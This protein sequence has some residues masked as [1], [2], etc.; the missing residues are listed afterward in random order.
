MSRS[1]RLRLAIGLLFPSLF[2]G[3][4]Y[5]F[6]LSRI[7]SVSFLA[8]D[9]GTGATFWR[10]LLD[11]GTWRVAW[12][13]IWQASL[14]T[15][16]TLILGL[17]SAYLFARFRFPGKSLLQAL[18]AIPFILPTLVV[19]AAFNAL[20]GPRGWVNLVL[21]SIFDLSAPPIQFM[22]TI[23]A[24]LTAH[25]FYNTTIV[26]RT[27]SSFWVNLDPKLEQAA[28]MLG[29][30]RWQ[31]LTRITLPLIGPAVAVACLLVFIFNFTS[32]GVILVLGGP[33]FRTFEVEIFTQALSFLNLHQAAAISILQLIFTAGFTALYQRISSRV[34]QP[35]S[36]RP[37]TITQKDLN[38][39][40]DR[41]VVVVMIFTLV[42]ILVT[43]LLALG[44]RSI[45]RY[46]P[47]LTFSQTSEITFTLD[48]Y[49]E[50]NQNRRQSLFFVSPLTSVF[51]SLQYAI[52][53]VFLSLLIGMPAAW[54]LAR[55]PEAR[56][57][58][59]L[60]LSFMLPLGTSSVT[61]GLGFILALNSPPFDLRTSRLLIPFAHT[62]VALPFVVRNLVPALRS[63]RPVLHQAASML[64]AS[65]I[66]IVRLIDL[67]LANRAML[68]AATF[69]F[70]ISLG[71]FGATSL[72]SRPEF[73]TVPIAIY[74]Y[75]GQPGAVNYG[76]A[77]ALSTLL[78]LVCLSGMLLIEKI[79]PKEFT[80]F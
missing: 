18:T 32:F 48:F 21:M 80:E 10:I 5:F 15:L 43:P 53:T 79:R 42:S 76:Q 57:L 60:D 35:I 24:I 71:E 70:T 44:L 62:L 49:R 68:V 29:A 31:T 2:L 50:L 36:L 4:F 58:R 37:G 23:G 33:K 45:T 28:R 54:A 74:R 40:K 61:L 1:P 17:P 59:L 6:P 14:S 72:I 78:M 20:L 19:A 7:L 26:I 77:L 9:N 47:N 56:V 3:I 52:T 25:V 8:P 63:I 13:T 27:V 66:E 73:P 38:T 69:A 22:N 46:D 51:I 75:L 34:T 11:M 64:G 67:P 30:S 39:W 16:L 12:F 41:L 55:N 65:P